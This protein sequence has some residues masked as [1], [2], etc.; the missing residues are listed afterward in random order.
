MQGLTQADDGNGG[1]LTAI[2]GR[3]RL[4]GLHAVPQDGVLRC[5][6]GGHG[7]HAA[8]AVAV[9]GNARTV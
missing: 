5:L 1:S 3:H 6:L 9:A 4:G 8:R 7:L 2:R